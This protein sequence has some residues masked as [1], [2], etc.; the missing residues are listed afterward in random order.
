MAIIALVVST[1]A[2]HSD[3]ARAQQDDRALGEAAAAD[4][5]VEI[6]T[7]DGRRLLFD[8]EIADAP[9]ERSR[10]LM[11]R[12]YMPVDAGMLFIFPEERER[13]FWMRNTL[14]TLDIIYFDADGRYVSA[15]ERAV[16]L[17]ETG[18]PSA[19]PAQYV[20]EIN[21][22]LAELVGIGPGAT[23]RS[24]ALESAGLGLEGE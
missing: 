16:P 5:L 12:E 23:L 19:G 4:H 7:A 10:G 8:V 18:L 11:F 15:A 24:D 2:P 21:G 1:G 3:R 17:D 6:R 13:S 20:L 14:I 22:G 9:Q